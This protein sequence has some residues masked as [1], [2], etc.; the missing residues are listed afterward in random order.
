L[1][2]QRNISLLSNRLAAG[3]GLRIREDVLERD[4]CLAWLLSAVSESKLKPVL[5]VAAKE[6]AISADQNEPGR[7]ELMAMKMSPAPQS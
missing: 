4:Y 2:P 6:W 3:G 5:S 7:H 1:I